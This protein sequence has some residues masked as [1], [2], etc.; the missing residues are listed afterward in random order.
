MS[1]SPTELD[2]GLKARILSLLH[3]GRI[4]SV[5]TLRP[6]GWPQ[7]TTVGYV[8]TDLVLYFAVASTSQKFLNI[9]RDPRVSIAIAFAPKANRQGHGL[10]MAARASQ[11]LEL[12][13]VEQINGALASRYFG[14]AVFAP[15]GP[16]AVIL[17]AEP[18][19]I[20][21]VDDSDGLSQPQVFHAPN[22]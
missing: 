14:R 10:S 12:V 1:K 2:Q 5:A 17:R 4:M 7:V 15:R 16:S 19:I 22:H 21:L 6:D 20:S 3:E 11:V 18:T 13:E 8:H 9:Q